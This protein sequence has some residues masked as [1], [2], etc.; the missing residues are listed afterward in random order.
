MKPMTSKQT[1]K[2]YTTFRPSTALGIKAKL[3]NTP[4][5]KESHSSNKSM[6]K[7]KVV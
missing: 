4:S 5:F 6:K 1:K 2:G 7:P 3:K